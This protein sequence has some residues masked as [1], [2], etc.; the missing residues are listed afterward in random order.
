M[1][2]EELM[3]LI[4]VHRGLVDHQFCQCTDRSQR[5]AQFVRHRRHEVVLELVQAL[6]LFVGSAQL[7]GRTLQRQRLLLQFARIGAQLRSFV[8]DAHHIVE[9]ER[10]LLDRGSHHHARRGAANRA[11]ELRLDEL[12]EPRV[13]RDL[14]DARHADPPRIVLEHPPRRLHAEKAAHQRQQLG[15]LGTT[16]PEHRPVLAA[17]VLGALEHVDEQQRLA[18]LLC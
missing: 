15:Y 11:S 5:R 10:L 4:V 9:S 13:G 18:G 6:Q 16:A 2:R 1:M 7:G 12:D 14:F 8:E 3:A 17:A